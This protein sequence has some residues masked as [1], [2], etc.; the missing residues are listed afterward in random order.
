[1]A[2]IFLSYFLQKE[3][4]VR[5][6]KANQLEQ[7]SKR[8]KLVSGAVCASA[9]AKNGVSVSVFELGRGP[10]GRMSQRRENT[11]DGNELLFD[12]GAP[13]FTVA[14]PD[15]LALVHEW[16]SRGLVAPWKE[17]FATFDCTTKKFV[18]IHQVLI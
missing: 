15:V 10:G 12:H 1:M 3:S 2:M 7:S 9:L 16:E 13:F 8:Q 4:M 14:N 6:D 17:N 18:D 11:G 5:G